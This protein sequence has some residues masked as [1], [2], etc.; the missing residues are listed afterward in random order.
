MIPSN[1]GSMPAGSPQKRDI[2]DCGDP[3]PMPQQE[4]G[5]SHGR[6]MYPQKFVRLVGY[7]DPNAGKHEIAHRLN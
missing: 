6:E 5:D 3:G 1:M 7:H 4:A 2:I